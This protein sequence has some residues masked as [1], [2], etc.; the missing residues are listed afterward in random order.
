MPPW[1]APE[2]FDSGADP[3][4]KLPAQFPGAPALVS[5][6]RS[7]RLERPDEVIQ[8]MR[9]NPWRDESGPLAHRIE[10]PADLARRAH[11]AIEGQA[12]R[13]THDGAEK[14]AGLLSPRPSTF[15]PYE[16]RTAED[17]ARSAELVLALSN[18]RQRGAVDHG[19]VRGDGGL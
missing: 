14:L 2:M 16:L 19:V 13:H 6:R 9:S 3:A 4:L 1:V 18:P 8:R 17:I 11:T 7:D 5:D 15:G 12:E 10:S